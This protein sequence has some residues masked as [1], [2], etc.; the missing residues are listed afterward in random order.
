[1]H[2]LYVL[3]ERKDGSANQAAPQSGDV[4]SPSAH[5][6]QARVN[7]ETRMSIKQ[8]YQELC[9]TLTDARTEGDLFGHLRAWLQTVTSGKADSGISTVQET[10]SLVGKSVSVDETTGQVLY[11]VYNVLNYWVIALPGG[12][13]ALHVDELVVL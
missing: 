2:I 9:A 13:R 10:A 6:P 3:R 7:K 1:M 12:N 5:G 4:P 11:P 8:M